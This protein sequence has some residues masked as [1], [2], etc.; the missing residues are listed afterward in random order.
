MLKR[1]KYD[2]YD[3]PLTDFPPTTP[4]RRVRK[5]RFVDELDREYDSH[6]TTASE[7]DEIDSNPDADSILEGDSAD[8]LIYYADR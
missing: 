5:V 3:R 6:P 8:F 1:F 2:D 4:S 7:D